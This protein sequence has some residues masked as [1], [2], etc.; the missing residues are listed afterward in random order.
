MPEAKR[1]LV[2]PGDRLAFAFRPEQ[3][4]WRLAQSRSRFRPLLPRGVQVPPLCLG[5]GKP[6]GECVDWNE[7]KICNFQEQDWLPS[8]VVTLE[9]EI[10]PSELKEVASMTL[11]FELPATLSEATFAAWMLEFMRA[12]SDELEEPMDPASVTF[13]LCPRDE[14]PEMVRGWKKVFEVF[15]ASLAVSTRCAEDDLGLTAS[16]AIQAA[17]RLLKALMPHGIW[18]ILSSDR[19]ESFQLART[20]AEANPVG[21]GLALRSKLDWRT[22]PAPCSMQLES[23]AQVC[24]ILLHQFSSQAVGLDAHALRGLVNRTAGS[25]SLLVFKY[26]EK[27]LIEARATSPGPSHTRME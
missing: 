27:Q 20:L 26:P 16:E 13:F 21:L 4:W 6:Q 9:A 12:S 24:C 17:E 7:R 14:S 25:W 23:Q 15:D 19:D 11:A 1:F 10:L 5:L 22:G 8:Q 18:V 3:R 2:R